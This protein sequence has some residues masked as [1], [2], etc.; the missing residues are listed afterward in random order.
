MAAAAVVADAAAEPSNDLLADAACAPGRS[1]KPINV[2]PNPKG[3]WLWDTKIKYFGLYAGKTFY[4]KKIRARQNGAHQVRAWPD[5]RLA[6]ARYDAAQLVTQCA[7]GA[8][9]KRLR[10]ERIPT[11]DQATDDYIARSKL[12]SEHN[13]AQVRKQMGNHLNA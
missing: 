9:A 4:T 12:R 3:E 6:D 11:L 1:I 5:T 2:I 13:K 8:V 7:S 10:A